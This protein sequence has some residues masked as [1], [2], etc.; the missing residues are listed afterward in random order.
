M[1]DL[2]AGRVAIVTGSGRGIGRGEA[3][4]LAAEGAKVVVN[5]PGVE[6]DGHGGSMAPAD[7]VVAA[8]KAAGGE[9]V[10]NYDSVA[11][12][13]GAQRLVQTAVDSFGRLDI[14]VNNAG[15]VRRGFMDELTEEDFD[16]VVGVHL[17]GTFAV[18][19]H[20]VPVMKAQRYGRIINT[21]SNQFTL[22]KGRAAYAAA[23]GGIV[24]LTYDLAWEL[25]NDGITVNA[26]APFAATRMTA[27][28]GGRDAELVAKGLLSQRRLRQTEAR[29]DPAMVAPMV[30]YL[31]SD[32]AAHVT[33]CVFRAG[34]GKIGQY[35]HPV[36]VRTIFRNEAAE[37]P[38]PVAELIDLLPRTVLS[39]E[40]K[41][42]H[43]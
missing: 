29:T 4:A 35:C 42:P 32:H 39:G 23:K 9:A 3:L 38:W 19:R 36:E 15:V 34:G 6:G 12:W 8:I 20:A 17:K 1:G 14:V 18:C 7:E 27:V 24:S 40:T 37:G 33:G 43:I 2:L 25:Q 11:D 16:L 22:P 13:K 21:A 5:D 28:E 31:A 26:V 41:A 10:A 30:V